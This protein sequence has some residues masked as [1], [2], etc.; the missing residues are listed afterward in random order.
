M[1]PHPEDVMHHTHTYKL[2]DSLTKFTKGLPDMVKRKGS[3][4]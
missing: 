3:S 2:K 1:D 4:Q